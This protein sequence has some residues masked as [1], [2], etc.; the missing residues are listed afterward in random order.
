MSSDRSVLCY[1]LPVL[2]S[3]FLHKLRTYACKYENSLWSTNGVL[4]FGS[5]LSSTRPTKCFFLHKLWTF[6][7]KYE[8]NLWSTYGV[9]YFGFCSVL[10]VLQIVFL[11]K[12]R[13]FICLAGKRVHRGEIVKERGKW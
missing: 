2:Q 4:Y 7:C 13:T 10:P 3:V 6:A 8:N 1:V 11:H 5:L 9:R 12:L